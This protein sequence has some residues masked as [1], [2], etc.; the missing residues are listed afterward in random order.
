[1]NVSPLFRDEEEDDIELDENGSCLS[2]SED[3]ELNGN[4]LPNNTTARDYLIRIQSREKTYVISDKEKRKYIYNE[5]LKNPSDSYVCHPL[6]SL[7]EGFE[8]QDDTE[9]LLE[10]FALQREFRWSIE[11]QRKLVESVIKGF[12]IGLIVLWEV[13]LDENG[14]NKEHQLIDGLH[15]ITTLARFK[16][17]EFKWRGRAYNDLCS[18]DKRNFNSHKIIC[19]NLTNYSYGMARDFFQAI[20]NSIALSPGEYAYASD[21][22]PIIHYLKDGCQIFNR[23][24]TMYNQ[25]VQRKGKRKFIEIACRIIAYYLSG[26]INII[27][28]LS[29][30]LEYLRSISVI[31]EKHKRAIRS[32]LTALT[33]MFQLP[34]P[35]PSLERNY[36]QPITSTDL[37]L[38]SCMLKMYEFTFV[39][40]RYFGNFY[41]NVFGSKKARESMLDSVSADTWQK[42]IRGSPMQP[43]S[44][45]ERLAI[46]VDAVKG[47]FKKTSNDKFTPK[48]VQDPLFQLQYRTSQTVAPSSSSTTTKRKTSKGSVPTLTK[49]R[50]LC[51]YRK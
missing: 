27:K 36:P 13:Y 21:D 49:R 2:E 34:D 18:Q 6:K 51:T 50:R 30:A 43:Q 41:R 8:K 28:D 25:S 31:Q 46:L 10:K 16:R 15:R 48:N 4:E 9:L 35:L 38:I 33:I 24:C 17:G 45:K 12:T 19:L 47:H 7:V 23:F 22:I 20:Q 1:M 37:L 14:A 40:S 44:M 3:E 39:D 29:G 5:D 11:F 26:N 32:I 42:S